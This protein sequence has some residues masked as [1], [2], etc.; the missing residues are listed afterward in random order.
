SVNLFKLAMAAMRH[1]QGRTRI[2]TDDLNFPSDLYILQGVLDLCGKQYSL[3][4]VPSPDAIYGPVAELQARLD[5]RTALLTLSHTTFKSGYV[6]DMAALTE[7]AHA[8]GALV[9]W[10]LSHSVGAVPVDLRAAGVDMAIGCSYKYLNGGPGAPAFLYMRR[11]LQET[12]TNPL[13]GWMGQKDA[14]AF[15]LEYQPAPGLRRFLTGTPPV[16]SLALIEAGV[17]LL[18]EAGIERLRA[19]SVRQSAY[20]I[21]LWETVLQPLGFRL[22]SPGDARYRG[23]HIALGHAEAL[24]IDQALI[25]EM[26][27]LPDFRPPDTIRLGIAPIYTTFREIHT[28]VMRLQQIVEERLYEKY[29]TQTPIVT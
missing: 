26:P 21:A 16:I 3:E 17:D 19:K 7:A 2:M 9:L 1:Q 12:L 20:L 10:D 11:D 5:Q 24:G 14:F 28:S 6:Y 27:V 25:H 18:L 13:S 8:A 15:G 22:N 23:S 4:V 29:A